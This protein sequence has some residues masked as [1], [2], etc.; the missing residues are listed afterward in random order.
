MLPWRKEKKHKPA[1]PTLSLLAEDMRVLFHGPLSDY[2]LPESV[3]LA[4]SEEFFNDPS[5]CE[6]HRRAVQ[7][8]LYA[9]MQ[10]LLPAG[11]TLSMNDAPPCISL[12]CQDTHAAFIRLDA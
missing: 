10:E 8:R 11:Q 5:P 7:L 6:I 9:E 2:P 1:P 3:I 12:Y 4:C